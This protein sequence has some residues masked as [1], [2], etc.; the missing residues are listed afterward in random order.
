L[1][2]T[3][4]AER[5]GRDEWIIDE[6][7]EYNS[8]KRTLKIKVGNKE[9]IIENVEEKEKDKKYEVN[10]STIKIEKAGNKYKVIFEV[11][12]NEKKKRVEQLLTAI[13]DGLYAQS[14]GEQNTIN[15]LFIISA[16]VK[17]PCPIFHPYI[18]IEEIEKGKS[19]K[20]EGI[21][22]GFKNSW[23][24]GKVYIWADGIKINYEKGEIDENKIIENW[25][26][27]LKEC[28]IKK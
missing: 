14:S 20:V 25:D 21:S 1:S 19:Y 24:C 27:F 8:N 17:V 26:E 5:L 28:G 4:D 12:E 9:K 2:F 16:P 11:S 7:P 15:P 3:I 22:N 6:R 10:G 18:E 23:L 13:K